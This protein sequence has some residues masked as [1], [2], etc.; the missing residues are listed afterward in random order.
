MLQALL[1]E[2]DQ[3]D[4]DV[5]E[6]VLTA[7]GHISDRTVRRARQE[8]GV[9]IVKHADGTTTWKLVPLQ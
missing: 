3:V 8:L 4:G 6:R 1:R 5:A 7:G 9:D 2:Y